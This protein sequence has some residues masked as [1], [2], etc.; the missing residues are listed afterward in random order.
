M[1]IIIKTRE[2]IKFMNINLMNNQIQVINKNIEYLKNN[3]NQMELSDKK[4]K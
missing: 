4:N 1:I 2:V 3:N